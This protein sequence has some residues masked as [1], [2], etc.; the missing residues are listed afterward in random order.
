MSLLTHQRVE[1][2]GAI[3]AL[4]SGSWLPQR[5]QQEIG[6]VAECNFVGGT[7]RMI[8]GDTLRLYVIE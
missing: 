4:L 6:V 7:A 5:H 8:Q 1:G 3:V 2:G